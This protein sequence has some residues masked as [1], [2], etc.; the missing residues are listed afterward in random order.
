MVVSGARLDLG[1]PDAAVAA[2][3]SPLVRA[4]SGPQRARVAEALVTALRAA[5]RV[6]E[7]ERLAATLPDTAAEEDEVLVYDLED[8]E[9]ESGAAAAGDEVT[10]GAAPD[11][12]VAPG[13][14]RPALVGGDGK[15]AE[16]GASG[17]G[18]E[19]KR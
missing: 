15:S 14:V 18:D 6:D 16:D 11:Q 10:A 19:G 7:A 9:P 2:L 5:G 13:Q 1:E 12:A 8:A 3:Q 17:P 4:A